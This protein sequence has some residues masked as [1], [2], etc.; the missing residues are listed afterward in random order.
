MKNTFFKVG[1]KYVGKKGKVF[2]VAEVGVN[3][4]GSFDKCTKLFTKARESGADA[5]K[6]QTVNVEKNYVQ[7]TTS[8]KEFKNTDFTNEKFY[9]LSLVAKKLGLSFFTTPGDFESVDKCKKYGS[10]AI[11]ISSGLITHLPLIEYASKKKLPIIISTGMAYENEI[12]NAFNSTKNNSSVALLKCTSLYPAPDNTLNVRGILS[13]K[14]KYN[15]PIGF[16]DHTLDD[17]SSYVAVLNGAS[18]IEKHFTLNKKSKGKDHAIS[19]EPK[20]FKNMCD[21]IKRIE[22]ILGKNLIEPTRSEKKL[23]TL[24]HRT[25][26]A[27]RS[28]K[29]DEIFNLE[30][31]GFKRTM[32]N[33]N[34]LAPIY[35]R[36]ILGKKNKKKIRKNQPIKLTN[37]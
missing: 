13:L 15:V 19:M 37:I 16:S 3:H 21:N 36:K 30:N 6:L 22:N 10:Q 20:E 25:I 17:F 34:G 32:Q 7:G 14:K 2:I 26:I 31:I 12:R 5:V 33:K 35:F 27:N 1:K 29:K 28:I 23:R 9:K 18:I 11:K 24:R 4:E 8:Y